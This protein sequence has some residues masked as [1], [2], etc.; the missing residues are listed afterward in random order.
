MKFA[1]FAQ[2]PKEIIT[3]SYFRD[4]GMLQ[5]L[6]FFIFPCAQTTYEESGSQHKHW[7]SEFHFF[8]QTCKFKSGSI[9]FY[10]CPTVHALWAV[11]SD[12][13]KLLLFKII[14]LFVMNILIYSNIHYTT[15]GMLWSKYF[16]TPYFRI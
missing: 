6:L 15:G 11:S 2:N 7:I 14:T 9:Q 5:H 4:E 1:Q 12:I 13:I 3:L 8:I 10:F 16:Q